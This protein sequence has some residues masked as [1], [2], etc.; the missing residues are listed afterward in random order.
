MEKRVKRI[1]IILTRGEG[2]GWKKRK[3]VRGIEREREREREREGG[4]EGEREERRRRSKS[5]RERITIKKQRKI[6][7]EK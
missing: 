5:N 1:M 7:T 3:T 4:R 2:N 6:S